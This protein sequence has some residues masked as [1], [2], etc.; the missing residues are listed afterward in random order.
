MTAPSGHGHITHAGGEFTVT[1]CTDPACPMTTSGPLETEQQ[2][3]ALPE[4]QAVYAG[5]RKLTGQVIVGGMDAP[6][7]AML[8]D[9]CSRS[10][11]VTGAFERRILAWL[12]GYEP[13]TVAVVVRLVEGAY[14]AG[15]ASR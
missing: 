14:E 1:P 9:A 7:L 6:N 12:A 13:E 11:V 15:R 10:G 3:R 2:A 5:F 8:E 4:V